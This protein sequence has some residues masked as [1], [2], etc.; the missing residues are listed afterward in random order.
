MDIITAFVI[1]KKKNKPNKKK[2]KLQALPN[3]SNI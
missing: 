2:E 3:S 1:K